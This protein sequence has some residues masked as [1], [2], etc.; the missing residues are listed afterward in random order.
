MASP[1]GENAPDACQQALGAGQNVI[2]E[3]RTYAVPNTN[4]APPY[5]NPDW[6][7]RDA[8]QVAKAMLQNVKP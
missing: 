6:A 8:E 4:A 1:G 5:S 3:T 7:T 2:V